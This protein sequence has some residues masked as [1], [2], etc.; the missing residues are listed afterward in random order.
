MHR[1]PCKLQ[2]SLEMESGS[3]RNLN[4]ALYARVLNFYL[5]LVSSCRFRTLLNVMTHTIVNQCLRSVYCVVVV[6]HVTIVAIG[7]GLLEEIL[8]FGTRLRSTHCREFNYL[9]LC[10]PA[11]FVRTTQFCTCAERDQEIEGGGNGVGRLADRHPMLR[12][13]SSLRARH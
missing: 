8:A 12:Q 4:L 7:H 13:L 2:Q 1:L 3:L 6:Y 10:R 11:Y 5:A 9:K